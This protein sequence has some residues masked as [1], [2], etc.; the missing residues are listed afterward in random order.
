MTQ[1]GLPPTEEP[2]QR[3]KWVRVRFRSKRC[4]VTLLD[5]HKMQTF[6][7][8]KWVKESPLYRLAPSL[9]VT[10]ES[11]THFLHACCYG[12]DI[13]MAST[14]NRLP[15]INEPSRESCGKNPGLGIGAHPQWSL[16][17]SVWSQDPVFTTW[18]RE[19]FLSGLLLPPTHSAL[20][21][22]HPLTSPHMY[23][24]S[25]FTSNTLP[26]PR[27]YLCPVFPLA[28]PSAMQGKPLFTCQASNHTTSSR[29]HF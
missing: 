25:L 6:P 12:D 14:L 10:K 22:S 3:Q 16:R 21:S 23:L 19:A 8:H 1:S 5:A 11:M 27:L 13:Q 28:L 17:S 24:H 29:K 15:V 18:P 2:L 26:S 20:S 7:F 4:G 9:L